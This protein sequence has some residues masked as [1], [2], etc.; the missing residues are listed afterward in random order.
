MYQPK[1]GRFMSRDPLPQHGIDTFIPFLI[2]GSIGDQ[3][4]SH[5]S[6]CKT[7]Q[8]IARTPAVDRR[9]LRLLRH[10][11]S[12]LGGAQIGRRHKRLG[13]CSST[14]RLFVSVLVV[15]KSAES[16]LPQTGASTNLLRSAMTPTQ[17]TSSRSYTLNSVGRVAFVI[18]ANDYLI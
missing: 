5:M 13:G 16:K 7:T 1:L 11:P 9:H 10:H 18:T 3:S 17:R 14:R 6:T 4:R 8:L 12:E 2:C 15:K